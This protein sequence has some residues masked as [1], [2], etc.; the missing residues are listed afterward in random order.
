M[1]SSH[2]QSSQISPAS[3]PIIARAA[4][5]GQLHIRFILLQPFS[6]NQILVLHPLLCKVAYETLSQ[7]TENTHLSQH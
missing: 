3:Y 5:L 2:S 6:Q 1:E 7:S 4:F